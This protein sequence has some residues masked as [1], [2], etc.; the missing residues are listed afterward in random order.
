M[1]RSDVEYVSLLEDALKLYSGSQVL[2]RVKTLGRGALSPGMDS[3]EV[4]MLL[5]DI[6]A[7]T[8]PKSGCGP[9]DIV[10]WHR[11]YLAAIFDATLANG[12][13][14]DSFLG[15]SVI[16]WFREQDAENACRAALSAKRAVENLTPLG[17]EKW[18]KVHISQSIHVGTC[19]VGAD[20]TDK[21]LRFGMLGDSLN[22]G[23]AIWQASKSISL[24]P[25]VLSKEAFV[26]L[27]SVIDAREESLPGYPPV[28]SLWGIRQS[29]V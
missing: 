6:A 20:G 12:G 23:R 28:Y 1:H 29:S 9:E 10:T 15:E 3:R 11:A 22:F 7:Y 25:P 13:Y 16:S 19:Q 5:T 4:A 8:F 14:I 24:Y 27:S 17:Q 18:P 21:R 2:E 26:R